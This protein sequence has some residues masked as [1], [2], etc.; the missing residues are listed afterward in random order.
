MRSTYGWYDSN[1]VIG[2]R[3]IGHVV[4]VVFHMW[5]VGS[6]TGHTG[7]VVSVICHSHVGWY[8]SNIVIGL[9][10]KG[11]VVSVVFCICW[12]V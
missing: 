3:H 6:G 10:H 2:L 12:V 4:S 5:V 1:I 11:H 9:E 7:H 8:G